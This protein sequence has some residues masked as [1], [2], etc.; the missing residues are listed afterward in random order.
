MEHRNAPLTRRWRT[1]RCPWRSGDEFDQQPGAF[2]RAF[3]EHLALVIPPAAPD[4]GRGRRRRNS[5]SRRAL[6]GRRLP[7]A[8]RARPCPALRRARSGHGSRSAH[9]ARPLPRAGPPPGRFQAQAH[10]GPRYPAAGPRPRRQRG[11]LP[12]RHCRSGGHR[13]HRRQVS[14]IRADQ[15][16]TLPA[17]FT[18]ATAWPRC[19][20]TATP[21]ETIR[22]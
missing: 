17:M 2:G 6:S 16:T 8:R 22:I 4:H 20:L 9:P 10:R 18:V 3:L 5:G 12:L 15:V 11:G 7:P 13:R 21:S 19:A 14:R 1:V